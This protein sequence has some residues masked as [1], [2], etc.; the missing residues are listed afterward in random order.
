MIMRFI[1]DGEPFELTPELVRSRLADQHPEEVREYWVEIN[2]ACW[3]V[4]QALDPR[5]D[6]DRL[7][8]P[9]PAAAP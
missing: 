9:I 4:K 7:R 6:S 3:P 5:P 8:R 2:G 1:M